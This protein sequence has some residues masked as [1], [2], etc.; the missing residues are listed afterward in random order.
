MGK[1]QGWRPLGSVIVLFRKQTQ[2][3]PEPATA[4]QIVSVPYLG[5]PH[6]VFPC[7]CKKCHALLCS[8]PLPTSY[9]AAMYCRLGCSIMLPFYLLGSSRVL[10]L[11]RSSV[12]A[13]QWQVAT[14]GQTAGE[15]AREPQGALKVGSPS[16]M[17]FVLG[18]PSSPH[19]PPWMA[20]IIFPV[21]VQSFIQHNT[22]LPC[23]A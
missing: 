22:D 15:S 13:D 1:S 21:S 19:F 20:P 8:P 11:S 5:Q 14:L 2:G 17:V 23:P 16:S 9:R 6:L 4:P 10:S 3:A 12:P 18:N 7:F